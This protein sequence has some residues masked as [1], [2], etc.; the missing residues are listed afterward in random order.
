MQNLFLRRILAVF[1]CTAAVAAFAAVGGMV[2][3]DRQSSS[4][5]DDAGKMVARAAAFWENKEFDKAIHQMTLYLQERPADPGAWT[6]FGEYYQQ[7]YD[8][9]KAIDCYAKAAFYASGVEGAAIPDYGVATLGQARR[10]LAVKDRFAE[11][12]FEISPEV[13]MTRGMQ[14]TIAHKNLMP[15]GTAPGGID[16]SSGTLRDEE[17]FE[18]TEWFGIDASMEWLTMSGGFNCAVWQ[19]RDGMGEIVGYDKQGGTFR[20]KEQ[21]GLASNKRSSTVQIPQGRGVA[22][23]RVTFLDRTLEE[24]SSALDI[25]VY[26]VYGMIPVASE[27][28]PATHM[29]LPDL[30]EGAVL[31]YEGGEWGVENGDDSLLDGLGQIEVHQGDTISVSGRLCGKLVIRGREAE[32]I[33]TGGEYGVR[34][35]VEAPE[36]SIERVGAAKGL[37]FNYMIGSELASQFAN[38]FDLIYP[39]SG[40]KL[41][42]IDSRGRIVYEG[43]GAFSRDGANGD[44]MVE[45]PVHYVKR[46]VRDGYEYVYISGKPRDG[47]TVDPSFVMT[48]GA[49][50]NKI[51]VGA[52]L[53][54]IEGQDR[55][56]SV[57]GEHPLVKMSFNRV[58]ELAAGKEGFGELDIF[59]WMTL[60]RLFLVETATLN[61]QSLFGGVTNANFGSN[62][63]DNY[64]YY[65]MTTS[66]G[67]TNRIHLARSVTSEKYRPGDAV[68]VYDVPNRIAANKMGVEM[69]ERSYYEV[70]AYFENTAAWRRTVTAVEEGE[71]GTLWVEFSGV[72]IRIQENMTMIA[73][74]PPM[75]GMT[76]GI[77]YH[78]GAVAGQDG[79]TAFKYRN[80]EN[81]YALCVFLDGIRINQQTAVVTYP[82]GRVAEI[83]YQLAAQPGTPSNSVPLADSTV[84]S[85]GYD[86]ANPLIMLPEKLGGQADGVTGY[87]DSWFYNGNG[88]DMVLTCGLTWDLRLYAG[89]FA[90]RAA[91]A[92]TAAVENGS[93]LMRRL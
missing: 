22:E 72:P 52:Y 8:E 38:D 48:G 27:N 40:I 36:G 55:I 19:F 87:G 44:V 25:P 20:S 49:I 85:M 47:Y 33:D 41:C 57:S 79:L 43:D 63:Y 50:V 82:D 83:G 61:S 42:N 28:E 53:S 89:L 13:K 10:S 35:M 65:A 24:G 1:L 7:L 37:N 34:W 2:Y 58:R 29:A 80:V 76:D 86:P 71:D 78:T 88:M 73:H 64:S 51:H 68:S 93:R 17:K 4:I 91:S 31:R 26:I 39:W 6:M 75:N 18:T 92:G 59:A 84:L 60:Q 70:L 90:Y 69:I 56:G 46:E 67:P 30:P 74:L 12:S 77:G 54:G 14:L 11:Y 15:S 5:T 62:T 21:N 81:L 3:M 45:I 23:A 16:N 66:D 32:D 9:E